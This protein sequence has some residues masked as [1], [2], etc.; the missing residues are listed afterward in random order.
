VT[1]TTDNPQTRIIPGRNLDQALRNFFESIRP[2]PLTPP[3]YSPLARP[4]IT[5]PR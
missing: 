4:V 3:P 5:R 1:G 2:L